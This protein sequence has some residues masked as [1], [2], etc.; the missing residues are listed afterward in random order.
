MNCLEIAANIAAVVGAIISVFVYR[1]T[2]NREKRIL[3]IENFSKIRDKYPQELYGSNERI[4]LDYLRDME[5][6][7]LGVNQ[8]IYSFDIMQKMSGKRLLAQ[9]ECYMKE[10]ISERRA[11]H[12]ETIWIEYEKTMNRLYKYYECSMREGVRK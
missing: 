5:F 2:V 3:T 11:N 6:F 7:C 1:G 10:F 9:Y 12:S 8:N 4:K